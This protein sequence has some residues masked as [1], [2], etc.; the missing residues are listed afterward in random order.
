MKEAKLSL[1]DEDNI[2][3]QISTDDSENEEFNDGF[4]KTEKQAPLLN[5]WNKHDLTHCSRMN[6]CKTMNMNISTGIN[7]SFAKL[8]F[9]FDNLRNQFLKN[10]LK[11]FLKI[12]F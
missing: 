7:C 4:S 5:K 6:A 12:S 3:N 10:C 2:R 1:E 8:N 9:N 11:S